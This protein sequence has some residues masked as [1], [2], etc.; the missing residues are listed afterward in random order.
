MQMTAEAA[1]PKSLFGKH[2]ALSHFHLLLHQVHDDSPQW[3]LDDTCCLL[4]GS[5]AAYLY[6]HSHFHLR[7][8]QVRSGW[9]ERLT[10]HARGC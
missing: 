10:Q 3:L 4:Q 9:R 5:P 7:P 2:R 8:H 6:G 1:F